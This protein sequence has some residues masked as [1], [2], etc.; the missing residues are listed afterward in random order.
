MSGFGGGLMADL[1]LSRGIDQK[2]LM[3]TALVTDHL[4]WSTELRYSVAPRPRR[5]SGRA[6]DRPRIET[7][8]RFRELPTLDYFGLGP[9]SPNSAF[10]FGERELLAGA[11]ASWPIL[12]WL[13]LF[14]LAEYRRP[15]LEGGGNPRS[16]ERQFT[17]A[18]APGL[19]TQPHFVRYGL[20]TE[21]RQPAEP[22]YAADATLDYSI[23][24]DLDGGHSSFGQFRTTATWTT[25]FTRVT[26][27]DTAAHGS[28]IDKVFCTSATVR[29][30]N[31]GAITARGRLTISNTF[32]GSTVPFYYQP[33][34]GGTDIDG[35]D[36]L[37]GFT[38]YRFRAPDY[39]LGQLEY[40]RTL[41]GPLGW[42][43]FYDIGKVA[44]GTSQL[45]FNHVRQDFG[46]GLV[47]QI[48]GHQ[49]LRAYAGFGGG[50]GVELALKLT[51]HF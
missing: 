29:G 30:C 51:Q 38:D 35:F 39:W 43:A 36:T 12:G 5:H 19:T 20:G 28:L 6:V 17:E 26:P 2:D 33:T 11:S 24:Q 49:L 18:T 47:F 25:T 3:A 40:S 41:Y 23:F 8:A 48:A 31:Y 46:P 4:F 22:P 21:L 34:L 7:Y 10:T 27:S 13:R 37:R 1:D 14:A 42:L 45:D 50:E 9:T 32:P 15:L 16:V 44:L